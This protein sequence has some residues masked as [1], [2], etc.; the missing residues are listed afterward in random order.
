MKRILVVLFIFSL[1][2]QPAERIISQKVYK[3]RDKEVNALKEDAD[4]KG[5]SALLILKEAKKAIEASPLKKYRT[6]YRTRYKTIY[7]TVRIILPDSIT[8][9]A[10]YAF[11]PDTVYVHDTICISPPER[12][13]SFFKRILN[14]K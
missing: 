6:I 5:D 10:D 2:C 8:H 3:P 1:M 9:D 12:K 13:K 7:D 11:E 4:L 14:L